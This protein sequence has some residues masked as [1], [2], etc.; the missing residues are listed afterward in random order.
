MFIDGSDRS[1]ET[2]LQSK[3]IISLRESGNNKF[4]DAGCR[5]DC[6]TLSLVLDF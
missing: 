1:N 4:L 3:I 2:E 5:P 6:L